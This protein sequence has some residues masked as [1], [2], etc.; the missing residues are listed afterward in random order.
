MTLQSHFLSAMRQR[1]AGLWEHA[2]EQN[3]A[4]G[5]V[6]L[7]HKP[8]PHSACLCPKSGS[9]NNPLPK[10][11]SSRVP[12]KARVASATNVNG[13]QQV[14]LPGE[15]PKSQSNPATLQNKTSARV[16]NTITPLQWAGVGSHMLP[17]MLV[18]CHEMRSGYKLTDHAAHGT[19]VRGTDGKPGST[20]T[21]KHIEL[22]SGDVLASDTMQRLSQTQK[23]VMKLKGIL[24]EVWRCAARPGSVIVLTIPLT[25]MSSTEHAMHALC[26]CFLPVETLMA[27]GADEETGKWTAKGLMADFEA[28][29]SGKHKCTK[30]NEKTGAV[31]LQ[32]FEASNGK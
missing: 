31:K 20:Y 27:A 9:I 3:C 1:A 18:S 11:S 16:S 8:R 29:C 22:P 14:D 6:P 15:R 12:H 30:G 28:G 7:L 4:V 2:A 10:P 21:L 23:G 13:A 17:M 24:R 5:H 25:A 26:L 32:E 19:T